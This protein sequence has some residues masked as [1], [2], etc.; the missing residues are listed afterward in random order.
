V[1]LSP[2]SGAVTFKFRKNPGEM[3]LVDEAAYES[4]VRQA[5]PVSKQQSPGPFYPFSN[6]PLV[7][8]YARRLAES[9]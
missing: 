4:D 5:Q 9:A 7:R 2:P 6:Q 8:R 1:P 3:A